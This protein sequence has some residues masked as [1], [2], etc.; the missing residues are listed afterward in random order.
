MEFTRTGCAGASRDAG[1]Q[2]GTDE[3]GRVMDMGTNDLETAEQF[4]D[5]AWT[6][7]SNPRRVRI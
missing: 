2:S 4:E 5:V 6:S 3:W 7:V 1:W